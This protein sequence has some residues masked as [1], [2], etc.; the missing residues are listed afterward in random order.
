MRAQGPRDSLINIRINPERFPFDPEE[1]A[2]FQ[3][4]FFYP[5]LERNE[6]KTL[7]EDLFYRRVDLTTVCIYKNSARYQNSSI[8]RNQEIP[9][10]NI[11]SYLA[12][13]LK[14]NTKPT[15]DNRAAPKF[16]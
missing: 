14:G 1:S 9:L 16:Q 7:R 3:E 12:P 8:H 10:S 2:C 11:N 5:E 13:A 6:L 4:E 15:R